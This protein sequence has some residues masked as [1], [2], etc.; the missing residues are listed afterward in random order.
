MQQKVEEAAHLFAESRSSGSDFP[1]YYHGFIAGAEW[2]AC[3]PL[4]INAKIQLP[5]DYEQ[6][7]ILLKDWKVR[8]AILDSFDENDFKTTY[9]WYDREI[10][11]SFDL[12]DV[13]AWAPI[14]SF[15]EIVI[16]KKK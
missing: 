7:L 14:P 1:A 11:E 5:K 9:F 6:K 10:D 2:Q 15:Y 4:W 13:V 12:E 16:T 3:H 8:I